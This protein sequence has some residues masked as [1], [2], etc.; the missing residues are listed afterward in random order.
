MNSH[1]IA[2]NDYLPRLCSRTIFLETVHNMS[3][4][5]GCTASCK[6]PACDSLKSLH[7]QTQPHT[8]APDI[9]AILET[10]LKEKSL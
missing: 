1:Y 7:E 5:N 9:S 3:I 8:N 10:P 4:K 2:V 6:L